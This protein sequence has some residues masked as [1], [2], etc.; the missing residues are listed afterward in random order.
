MASNILTADAL[1][2]T[3]TV[4]N[5]LFTSDAQVTVHKDA[6]NLRG[7]VCCAKTGKQIGYFRRRFIESRGSWHAMHQDLYITD[8]NF[9]S[10]GI[11]RT[12]FGRSARFYATHGVS[13]ISL[14]AVRDGRYV[15]LKYGFKPERAALPIIHT[16]MRLAY[17]RA[18]GKD[19]P[20][21][22]QLPRHGPRILGF[23]YRGISVGKLAV[24]RIESLTLTLDLKPIPV[25]AA[26]ISRG[27]LA[28][29][30]LF[31]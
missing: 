25:R 7:Q 2:S 4:S 17:R 11:A 22:T 19:F 3:Y 31:P 29:W 1:R 24:D 20:E 27:W 23:K 18:S 10:R 6:I 14:E 30:H 5:R 16:E 12:I 15:W 9:K 28:P 21:G 26:L 13:K 8:N